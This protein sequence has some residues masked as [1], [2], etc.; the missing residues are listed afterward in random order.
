MSWQILPW[1]QKPILWQHTEKGTSAFT[2]KASLAPDVLHVFQLE[3]LAGLQGR[4]EADARVGQS[5]NLSSCQAC[6]WYMW[7]ALKRLP[8]AVLQ[9]P[10]ANCSQHGITLT[11]VIF[12]RAF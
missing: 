1:R 5:R 3:T 9:G 10:L 2:S 4:K 11:M 8:A 6:D 7:A 12:D